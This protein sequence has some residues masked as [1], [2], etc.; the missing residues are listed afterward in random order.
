MLNKLALGGIK[1]RFRDYS[2]LFSG[3]MIASAIFYMFMTMAM[4]TKFLES[5]SPAAATVFIFGFG[6]VLL[7]IITVVYIGYANKFLMSMRE[8]EYGMFMM[9]GSKSSKISKMIFIETFAIGA[10]ASIIGMAVGIVATSF[11]GD[12]LMKSMDIPA[13]NFNSFYLPALIATMIFFLVIFI[14]SALRN[15]ISIRMTKVLNL[16]HKESQPTRIKRN[17]AWTVIQSILGIIFLGIGYVTMVRFGNS[18]ALIYIGVPIALV[19][20]VLGTYFVINSLTTTVINFLK[21]RPGVA[22]KG[23]NNFTLSQLNFR[24]GD[25]TKILSMVSIMFALALGA[26]TVGLG[27]HQQISTIV[28]GQQYYDANI[29]NMNDQERDQVDKLTGKKLN[30]YTYKSDAKNDYFRLSDFKD[31]PI[32]YNH[33]NYSSNNILSKT[34]TTSNPK[35][36]E[37]QYYL[38]GSMLGKD[39]MKKLQFVSDAEYAQIKSEPSKLTFV[40][41]DSF[42]KNLP[43]IRSISEMQLKRYPELKMGSG[44]KYQQYQTINGFFSG[45][46][47]MGFFLG[48]AFLAMLASCLMFKI[49]SGAAGDVK[50]Y[51]MLHKIGTRQRALRQSINKEI[52]VLF[53][54]PAVIGI[55]HVLV[56]VQ[57]FKALLVQPYAYIEIPF[58]IFLVPYL[59]YYFLTRYLY[60]KIVLK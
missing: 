52:A 15:S 54:V 12:T 56:G 29:V 4:N 45:L 37:V 18:P 35:N 47:F 36:E 21:K 58:L 55:V 39:R 25:Y 22:Q 13:K 2:V 30:E 16:L 40:K 59:G 28:N 7:A 3:L 19:T 24:I 34:K 20:I 1:H 14:L 44:D 38:Q 48:I 31:Q 41:T 51:Q 23:I 11:V 5:N 57:M 60:K 17:T 32:T 49:L 46:E 50:R 42:Q 33:F 43:T 53:T 10:I 6:A 8:K 26:I 9:L 27:F